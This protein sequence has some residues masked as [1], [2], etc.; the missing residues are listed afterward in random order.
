LNTHHKHCYNTH[1][2]FRV[3]T[4]STVYEKYENRSCGLISGTKVVNYSD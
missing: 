2:V 4:A 3:F 1:N